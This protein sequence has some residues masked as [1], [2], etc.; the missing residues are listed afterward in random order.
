[1]VGSVY[2]HNLDFINRIHFM[3]TF[4]EI[5]SMASDNIIIGT[6]DFNRQHPS[7]F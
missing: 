1:M 6:D 7:Q 5:T 2:E 4:S 3:K